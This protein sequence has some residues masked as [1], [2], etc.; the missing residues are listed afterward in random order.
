MLEAS[1]SGNT[2]KVFRRNM[3]V[4]VA[5]IVVA[6]VAVLV[7]IVGGV[8]MALVLRKRNEARRLEERTQPYS[9]YADRNRKPSYPYADITSG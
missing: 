1:D 4:P 7:V 6:G 2:C 5:I 9:T 8:A 3:V